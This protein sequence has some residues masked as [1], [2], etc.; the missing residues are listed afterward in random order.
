MGQN[1]NR[2]ET[3]EEKLSGYAKQVLNTRD[4][5]DFNF[6]ISTGA[7]IRGEMGVEKGNQFIRDIQKYR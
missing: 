2:S 1:S 5:S 7:K 4:I 6:Q 3:R